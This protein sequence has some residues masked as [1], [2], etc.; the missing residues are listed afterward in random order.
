MSN[1]AW[2][3]RR[4]RQRAQRHLDE[5]SPDT[6]GKRI[7]EQGGAVIWLDDDG[8]TIWAAFPPKYRVRR[9]GHVTSAV[10]ARQA[11]EPAPRPNHPR[12]AS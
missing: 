5:A 2:A 7:R 1:R 9:T 11:R 6:Y 10:L 3:R 4:A 8:I 12:R